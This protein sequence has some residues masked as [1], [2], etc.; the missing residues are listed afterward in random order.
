VLRILILDQLT[1]GLLSTTGFIIVTSM[2]ADVVEEVQV[3]T[4]RRAEGVLFAADSL[5]RKFSTSF[6]V[7]LP[8][9]LLN[10]VKFPRH[11]TPGQVPASVLTHLAEIYLP[12]ITVLYLCST[13]LLMIYR[14]DRSRHEANLEKIAQ[15]A[16]LSETTDQELTPHPAPEILAGSG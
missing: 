15:A 1:I 9:L 2:L 8:G 14:G 11:A 13:S 3:K 16:A 5:L 6:A 10:L 4:G 12:L 7:A